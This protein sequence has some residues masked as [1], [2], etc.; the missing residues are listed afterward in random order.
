MVQLALPVL[1]ICISCL[2][3]ILSIVRS[4]KLTQTNRSCSA[5]KLDATITILLVTAVYLVFNLPVFVFWIIYI[6]DGCTVP[7]NSRFLYWYSW[8]FTYVV[9]VAC[10]AAINPIVMMCRIA[11]FRSRIMWILGWFG[12]KMGLRGQDTLQLR[13]QQEGRVTTA[14]YCP[15]SVRL[16]RQV[17]GAG[18]VI[19][20]NRRE[21][22]QL[23][24][25]QSPT[26]PCE[27]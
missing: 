5:L 15:S 1:P 4:I 2:L 24:P 20:D 25:Q 26:T 22:T 17:N 23:L 10:N 14:T 9:L 27:G 19:P 12:C 11:K 6:K 16:T 13:Q 8:G 21:V 18:S 3:S 7:V